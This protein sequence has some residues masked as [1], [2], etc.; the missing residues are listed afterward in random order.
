MHKGRGFQFDMLDQL[1]ILLI[2]ILLLGANLGWISPNV[3]AYWPAVLV[4]L[5]LKEMVH[6]K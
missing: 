5:V 3:A 2:A 4:V 1:L 6:T